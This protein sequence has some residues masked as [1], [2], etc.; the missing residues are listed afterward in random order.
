MIVSHY[1]L[2]RLN[3]E[4][5]GNTRRIGK[6][7]CHLWFE[8]E[9]AQ[10]QRPAASWARLQ[11]CPFDLLLAGSEHQ[12]GKIR[13]MEQRRLGKAV[14][15]LGTGLCFLT[16][17]GICQSLQPSGLKGMNF[18]LSHLGCVC[19][20]GSIKFTLE[21]AERADPASTFSK[22]PK[23][24]QWCIKWY[25]TGVLAWFNRFIWISVRSGC[26]MVSLFRVES[27]NVPL[28]IVIITLVLISKGTGWEAQDSEL[29]QFRVK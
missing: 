8:G 9:G 4:K 11:R 12:S 29:R 18:S 2:S 25:V 23:L 10:L 6:A 28:A 27:A 24:P 14:A 3:Q 17:K 16:I 5:K 15:P 26:N 7:Y 13:G 1:L 20:E 19:L 21:K 22:L